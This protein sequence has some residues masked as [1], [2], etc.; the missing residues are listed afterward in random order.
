MCAKQNRKSNIDKLYINNNIVTDPHTICNEINSYFPPVG[1]YLDATLPHSDSSPLQCL[2]G[3]FPSI[4]LSLTTSQEIKDII[5]ELKVFSPGYDG[6]HAKVIKPGSSVLAPVPSTLINQSFR[7]GIF[8][9]PLKAAKIVPV[10][11][12]GDKL[13]PSQCRPLSV[14]S[15]I[16]KIIERK[17]TTN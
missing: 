6:V 1:E 7:S 16:G 2:N 15:T 10:H 8:P 14:L 12:G 11:K 3:N 9:N 5:T 13:Q 17:C 4:R